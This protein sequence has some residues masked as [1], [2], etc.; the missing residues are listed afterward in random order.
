ML[1]FTEYADHGLRPVASVSRGSIFNDQAKYSM[2]SLNRY[3]QS[4]G[5]AG[6]AL[7]NLTQTLDALIDRKVPSQQ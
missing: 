6:G 5:W 3:A 4:Q 2:D 7:D 1:H